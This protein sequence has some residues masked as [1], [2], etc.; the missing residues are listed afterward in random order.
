MY[1]LMTF[2][3]V[4]VV[5]EGRGQVAGRR[6]EIHGKLLSGGQRHVPMYGDEPRHGR[7]WR[8][9]DVV[10]EIGMERMGR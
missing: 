6:P 10:L 4:A 3:D 1:A 9:C 2:A 7:V 8:R 5:V